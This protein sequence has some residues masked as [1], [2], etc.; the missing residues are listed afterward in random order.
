MFIRHL[1]I[2]YPE[3]EYEQ[4]I[5]R[6]VGSGKVDLHN[7]TA[8][9]TMV[10]PV[11]FWQLLCPTSQGPSPSSLSPNH[12]ADQIPIPILQFWVILEKP[13]KIIEW[14][15][16][17]PNLAH[18]SI[19]SGSFFKNIGKSQNEP[20]MTQIWLILGGSWLILGYS[21]KFGSFHGI[22]IPTVTNWVR[23]LKQDNVPKGTGPTK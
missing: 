6:S 15:K 18:S 5:I 1:A 13:I 16:N 8:D 11:V 17:D 2:T 23:L 21:V 10:H 7:H 3:M 20:R 19:S 14:V 9:H 22:Q 4:P 12:P